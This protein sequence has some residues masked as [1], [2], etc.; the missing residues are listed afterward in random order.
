MLI[1]VSGGR[2]IF[3]PGQRELHRHF[4]ADMD[5]GIA[6]L[7]PLPGMDGMLVLQ[8]DA[9]RRTYSGAD[10]AANAFVGHLKGGMFI[11]RS[12]V[13]HTSR[14]YTPRW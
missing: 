8:T 12:A 10:S 7:A 2:I 4:G 11:H 1:A 5:T 3:R 14:S 9:A 13:S 6:G